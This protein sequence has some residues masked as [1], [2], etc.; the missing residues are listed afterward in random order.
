MGKVLRPRVLIGLGAVAV[1]VLVAVVQTGAVSAD[2]ARAPY[3][4]AAIVAGRVLTTREVTVDQ[5]KAAKPM[6]LPAPAAG[7]SDVAPGPNGPA[8]TIGGAL[9]DGVAVDEPAPRSVAGQV[10]AEAGGF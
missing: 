6:R 8:G 1:I 4:R 3:H 5:M 9:P 7:A 2:R 10:N